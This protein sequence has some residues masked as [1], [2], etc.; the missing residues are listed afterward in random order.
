MNLRLVLPP[1]LAACAERDAIPTK[2][3]LDPGSGKP[4]SPEK[5]G[6]AGLAGLPDAERAA[7]F[8][9]AQWCGG[10]LSSL[11]HLSK[12]HLAELLKMLRGIPCF[13]FAHKP[14]EPIDWDDGDL[15]GVSQHLPKE[16]TASDSQRRTSAS[17][18][19][20]GSSE[21][22][23]VYPAIREEAWAEYEGRPIE[24]EGST[25]YL[26]I[27]LPSDEHPAYKSTLRLL[28]ETN[29]LR[30]R[31]NR[32]WWW[33]RGREKTLDFLAEHK[34][35]LE[36][37]FDA[38]FT[39]NFRNHTKSIREATVKTEAKE[40]EGMTE[41]Q[42]TI[43]A[44]DAPESLVEQA[45]AMGSNHVESG[46]KVYLLGKKMLEKTHA[47]QRSL[48]G[49]H[50]A[51]LL[52]MGTYHLR[53]EQTAESE[54][55][56][57]ELDP[58]FKPPEI[59]KTRAT[60]LRD[61]N[62]LEPPPLSKE[63]EDVLRPYQK[64]G[65]GWM[66]HLFRH[67]LGGILADEMGLGKTLQT[68]AVLSCLKK[69]KVTFDDSVSTSLVVCPASL[70]ENWR[71]EA[72]RF[73]PEL[74]V[75]AHHGS[76]RLKTVEEFA[77]WDLVITSYGTLVRDE[78]LFASASFLCV[79]GDEAQNLKNR[80]T[81][82]AKSLASLSSRGRFLLTGT[83]VENSLNDLLS[84]TAFLM[85]GALHPIPSSSRGDDRTWHEKRFL[86][87]A[88]P[89]VLRRSKKIVAP[90]LPDKIEQVVYVDMTPE[91]AKTYASAKAGAEKEIVAMEEAGVPEGQLRMKTLTQ[92]LRLRQTCCDPR[93]LDDKL[94]PDASA[95]LSAFR[96]I[97][98]GAM[99]AGNRI[100]LF[101][102]FTSLLALIRAELEAESIPHCYLDGSSRDRMAQVDR[103]QNDDSVP[104]FLISLKAGGTGL[105]LTGA[106]LVIHFDPWWTPAA[107]A[108]AT[109]RA[110]RIGQTKTVQVYKLIV[111]DS[112]EENVL[113]L[114][115]SKRK[116]LSEVF[117][118]GEAANAS[119]SMKDLKEL[120]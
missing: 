51:P 38:T 102:Q 43:R 70:V 37:D 117:E 89:Y 7:A 83:P 88:A 114:Q 26:M 119:I 68:L 81:R 67:K 28:R 6:P 22:R 13:Y 71:R 45:L 65:V 69:R 8:V 116:L 31:Q 104:I 111:S 73:C 34:E 76:K 108:Q 85:P 3:E 64:I 86:A 59:W 21:E 17:S 48:S 10:E 112:V 95:K 105:N 14:Q 12:K 84:L 18:P 53:A 80:R 52:R 109:D 93:L 94:E 106:D 16:K 100:L 24:V 25:E 33:L 35:T 98:Y 55:I 23:E 57:V 2:L 78:N 4:V 50:E 113:R 27:T 96:E 107:E 110:H 42:V 60:G 103:F 91:Q 58:K 115:S 54:E 99:D 97:L 118:A 32:R 44:G 79:I 87:Q 77:K 72:E 63:L 66:L 41:I 62:K 101:S 20:S 11:L 15:L 75:F 47:L 90:E 74:S 56:L 5:A 92:L 30:D 40:K 120:I 29:F 82:N 1:T 61:L 39:E 19:T 9:M 46:G 49:S 36:L